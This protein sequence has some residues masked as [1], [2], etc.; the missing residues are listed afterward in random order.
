MTS[1]TARRRA[2]MAM[3]MAMMLGTTAQR[4]LAQDTVQDGAAAAAPQP[5]SA[6]A[7]EAEAIEV[8]VT[9]TRTRSRLAAAP[10]ATEVIDR[11]AI[12]RS[13]AENVAE[14][15][16]EHPGIQVERSF[17]GAGVRMQGL[18]SAYV[19][20]L[21]DG[22]RVPGRL[23][24]TVDL[25]RFN[26]E[27]VERI[28]IVKGASSALY[29]SDALGGVINII[30]RRCRKHGYQG[31]AHGSYGGFNTLDLSG[32]AGSCD[33]VWNTRFS[34]GFHRR[35]AF[36]LDESTLA[37]TGSELSEVNVDNRTSYRPNDWLELVGK[38]GYARR[39]QSA[40][41]ESGGGAVFDRD[42]RTETFSAS[43]GPSVALN[44]ASSVSLLAHYALFRDQFSQDQRGSSALDQYQE[45][46]EQLFEA[47]AQYDADVGDHRLVAGVDALHQHLASAR[48][49][50]GEGRRSRVALFAQ[51]EWRIAG[52]P[53]L[54]VVPGARL[55]V[56]SQFGVHPTPKIALRFD[57]HS[58][59]VLRASYGRGYRAPSF[60]ELLLLF[61]NPSVGYVVQGNPELEPETS[62]N[63]NVGAEYRPGRAL[64][65]SVNLYR[66]DIQSLIAAESIDDGG[67]GGP[68]RF[69]YA[70]ID[71][72]YTQGVEG[73][74]QVRPI[75]ALTFELGYTLLDSRDVARDRPLEGRATHSGTLGAR[76]AI[77]AINLE[78][79][80]R[81]ALYGRRPFYRDPDG[82]GDDETVFA[83]A[84]ATLDARIAQ[85]LWSD[86]LTIFGGIDN[87]LDAGDAEYLPIV[88]RALYAGLT[89]RFP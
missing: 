60:Q 14:V 39:D 42:N 44:D 63:F 65:L 50:A 64:W 31:E 71:S 32:R 76:Y 22:E 21:I 88:P 36:D 33:R 89:A 47:I 72:A 82:D 84:Y 4:S 70:N 9:G 10:V 40:I 5:K 67:A 18:D 56:D 55:D 62:H 35:D 11:E 86:H 69:S 49:G 3:A 37:T 7:E 24:G 17:R 79:S 58:T 27:N 8:V 25:S 48:L 52:E 81:S 57:P 41:D 77:E 20:V 75:D 80:V 34:G 43:L 2:A 6:E 16:E 28:E 45:T 23:D 12:E 78:L 1:G 15:L 61:E 38:V 29:G 73:L 46:R 26:T 54:V 53:R 30:T 59:V 51:D 66:N 87:A 68:Q 85:T 83:D 74:V 19:L 13:G